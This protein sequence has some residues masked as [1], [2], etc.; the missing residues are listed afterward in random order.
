MAASRRQRRNLPCAHQTCTCGTA[1]TMCLALVVGRVPPR[2]RHCAQTTALRRPLCRLEWPAAD[3]LW[4]APTRQWLGSSAP[5]SLAALLCRSAQRGICG[6]QH[7]CRR[8][9]VDA[10]RAT[11]SSTNAS[12]TNAGVNSPRASSLAG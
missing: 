2:V 7:G 11:N 6:R 8:I 5:D 9:A 1:I 3:L 10:H 4:D 12:S